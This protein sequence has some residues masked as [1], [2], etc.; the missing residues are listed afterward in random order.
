[1]STGNDASR[2][3]KIETAMDEC[4]DV[5][6]TVADNGPGFAAVQ[7]ERLFEAFYTTKASGKGMG[8]VSCRSIV[9]R[10]GGQ[11]WADTSKRARRRHN[12]PVVA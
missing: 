2:R 7:A 1:M 3:L 4:G 12:D 11:L 5:L 8:L 6:V 10:H 9:E